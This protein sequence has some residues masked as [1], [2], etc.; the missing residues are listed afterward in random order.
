M[1]MHVILKVGSELD[2]HARG[3]VKVFKVAV[4]NFSVKASP[5]ACFKVVLDRLVERRKAVSVRRDLHVSQVIFLLRLHMV[6]HGGLVC[7]IVLSASSRKNQPAF[8]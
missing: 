7:R 2:V 1:P 5:G 6:L 4:G 3:I 8:R